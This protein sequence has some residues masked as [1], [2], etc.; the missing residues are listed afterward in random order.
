MQIFNLNFKKNRQ[1]EWYTCVNGILNE[2]ILL[3]E[4]YFF[5]F[6]R[7]MTRPSEV[8]FKWLSFFM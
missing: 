4:S 1:T 6:E 5:Y 2:K 3:V 7:S 8:Y